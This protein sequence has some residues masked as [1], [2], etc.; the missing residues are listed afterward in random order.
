MIRLTQT[1]AVELGSPAFIAD[2][3]PV[4]A[5]LR[6]STPVLWHEPWQGWVVTRYAHV[7]SVL[8]DARRYSNA[9]RQV[10]L[11]Q[12]LPAQQRAALA[13]LT[14]HYTQ[15]GLSNQDP[16][17]HT[18]L[19]GLIARAFTPRMVEA[20]RTRIQALVDELLDAGRHDRG[21]D[22]I[23]AFAFPLPAL[24]IAHLMGLPPGDRGQ[25]KQWSDE[26]TAF[27][28]QAHATPEGAVQGQASLLQLRA[29]FAA[30][31]QRRRREPGPDLI[32]AL[33]AAEESGQ[34]LTDNELLG[35]CVTLL[36]GGHETTT[37]LIGNGVLAL[38]RHRDQWER[39]GREVHWLGVVDEVL[40]YDAPVQRAWR[41]V[42]EDVDLAGQ[43]LRRGEL[44]F[45]MLG[46]A[47]RDPDQCTDPDRLDV[48][49]AEP[50]HLSLGYGI[51]YCL[52]G[53]LARLEAA[54]ALQALRE[55][56]P[57][58]ELMP[59][60]EPEWK[61]NAAFRGLHSLRVCFG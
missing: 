6:V 2:P 11:L 23:P 12:R 31:L 20:M 53:A 52:G 28:G 16:P 5:R 22:L 8:Q 40:R 21:F 36:L 59:G 4:Y 44:V 50:R 47:N 48:D 38:M 3:Y 7:L 37:N 54:L 1:P 13:P 19:R 39:L 55:R 49:R 61:P 27:L 42:A 34:G 14:E 29:Y 9:G 46:S 15:G 33:L 26:L 10:R 58:L 25:F 43:R 51:H 32:S 17:E 18:R 30:Q 45:A 57:N 24:V 56:W 60:H 41:V 35:T